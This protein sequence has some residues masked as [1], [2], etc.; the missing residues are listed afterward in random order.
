MGKH[1]SEKDVDWS[2]IDDP[3]ASDEVCGDIKSDGSRCA[4]PATYDDPPRCGY[5]HEDSDF[6]AKKQGTKGG[7]NRRGRP[8]KHGVY[9]KDDNFYQRLSGREQVFVDKMYQS[10]LEAA[11]FDESAVGKA[12]MLWQV[13]LDMLKRRKINEYIQ[14]EG[15]VQLKT[16]AVKDDGVVVKDP[17]EN[18]L[19]LTYDRLGRTNTSILKKLDVFDHETEKAEA[20]KTLIEILSTGDIPERLDDDN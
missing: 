16:A 18:S 20:G 17:E 13:S 12:E 15:L 1:P 14:D 19:H 8:A 4:L 9:A 6:N 10:F 5:H 7:S 3:L 11:P 2:E